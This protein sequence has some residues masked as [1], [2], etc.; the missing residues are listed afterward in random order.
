[1][2]ADFFKLSFR[3]YLHVSARHTL[4]FAVLY[5]MF[6]RFIDRTGNL[7]WL[8]S[9][10]RTGNSETPPTS[11]FI[12]T[13]HILLF[14]LEDYKFVCFFLQEPAEG[15][16]LDVPGDFRG[17]AGGNGHS[18]SGHWVLLPPW[19]NLQ[20]HWQCVLDRCCECKTFDSYYCLVSMFV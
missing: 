1:M 18:G 13:Q 15:T 11:W 6:V 9:H 17:F 20:K 14:V 4:A 5:L 16:F 7:S 3:L 10:I 12:L 2:H 8:N 19:R